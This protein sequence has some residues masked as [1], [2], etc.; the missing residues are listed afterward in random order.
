MPA[1]LQICGTEDFL[2]HFNQHFREDLN[3]RNNLKINYMYK[4]EPGNHNWKFWDKHIQTTLKWIEGLL[5]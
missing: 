4:E 1:L 2:Y 5:N 3:N